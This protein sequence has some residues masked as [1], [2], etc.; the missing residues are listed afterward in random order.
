MSLAY[1]IRNLQIQ[2]DVHIAISQVCTH[3]FLEITHRWTQRLLRW[4]VSM[5]ASFFPM[6]AQYEINQRKTKGSLNGQAS[7]VDG[8]HA[9]DVLII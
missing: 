3:F 4:G 7:K 8:F 5:V 2:L 6:D 9:G 1:T